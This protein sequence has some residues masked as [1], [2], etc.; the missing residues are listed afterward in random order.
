M[1]AS[2]ASQEDNGIC[3]SDSDSTADDS[4]DYYQPISSVDDVG[5]DSDDSGGGDFSDRDPNS[6]FHQLP[7]GW[8]E[9]GVSSLDISDEDAEKEVEEATESERAIARAFREDEARRNAP[10]TSENTGRVMDAMHQISFGGGAPDWAGQIPEG[11]W[12]DRLRRLRP[13]SSAASAPIDH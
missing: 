13:P 4:S 8:V 1:N 7:N 10:L 2:A 11:Q 5:E 6:T 12:I 3:G 9:N